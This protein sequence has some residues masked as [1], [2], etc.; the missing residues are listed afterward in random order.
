M[1]QALNVLINQL[2]PKG[3]VTLFSGLVQ[4]G[5]AL[6]GEQAAQKWLFSTGVALGEGLP[7]SDDLSLEEL[8]LE[9][10]KVL[11]RMQWGYAELVQKGNEVYVRHMG[12]PFLTSSPPDQI[13][14]AG[15]LLGGLYY[16]WFTSLGLDPSTEVSVVAED[17]TGLLAEITFI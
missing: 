17:D 11:D 5:V 3:W 13:E 1:N 4:S 2:H 12:C 14:L 15:L 10:N 7:L 9:I 16:Q 8:Q 6:H